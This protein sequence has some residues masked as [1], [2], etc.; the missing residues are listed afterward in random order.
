M[1]PDLIPIRVNGET[2]QVP[3]NQSVAA[4]VQILDLPADRIAIEMDKTLVRKRDWANVTV[5]P[6]AQIEIV[7]FVGGG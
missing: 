1:Q 5:V 2:K 3:P 4:L 7:E 6:E